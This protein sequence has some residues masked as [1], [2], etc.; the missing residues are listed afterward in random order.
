[1]MDVSS[2]TCP[3]HEKMLRE[4]RSMGHGGVLGLRGFGRMASRR[5]WELAGWAGALPRAVGSPP[6]SSPVHPKGLVASGLPG[7]WDIDPFPVAGGRCSCWGQLGEGTAPELLSAPMGW[8][9]PGL[10]GSGP[11][12]PVLHR[13]A[14]H[15]THL[16]VPEAGLHPQLHEG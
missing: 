7:S 6:H 8:W 4:L 11:P 3:M 12:Y 13:T 5:V 14:R 10:W 15:R 16:P 2:C 9:E 1:M